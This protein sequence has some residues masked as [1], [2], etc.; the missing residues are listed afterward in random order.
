MAQAFSIPITCVVDLL[1]LE[2]DPRGP[3][4]GSSYNVKC[5]FCAD[6]GYHLNISELKNTYRC[7][8]CSGAQKGTGA[9]DLYGRVAMNTPH[10]PGSNGNGSY[11]YKRLREALGIADTS[12]L[13]KYINE[14]ARPRTQDILRASDKELDAAYS[15]LIKTV[16]FS[17]SE[18]HKYSLIKRGLDCSEIEKNQYRSIQDDLSWISMFPEYIRLYRVEGLGKLKNQVPALKRYSDNRLIAGFIVASEIIRNGVSVKGVPGFFQLGKRW[19]FR[20]DTGMIIPT[21]NE[22]GE[23]VSL[24]LRKDTGQLRYMTVSSKGF[25]MGVTEGISRTHFPRSNPEI[26]EKTTVILTEGPL[27]ADVALSLMGN[28]TAFIAMQGVN[29]TY[30]LPMV[31]AK[32]KG[33]G[34]NSVINA[35]DMDKLTNQNVSRACKTVRRIAKEYGIGMVMRCWDNE[36]AKTKYSELAKLCEINGIHIKDE[37][38][39]FTAISLMSRDLFAANVQHS[40]SIAEDGSERKNYWSALSKGIDDYLLMEKHK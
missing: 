25:P 23:I 21:R 26:N 14:N 40:V 2:R 6:K 4:Q 17:L 15:Q 39:I 3:K 29:N 7:V 11:L 13:K 18:H 10:I 9:L 24:Q 12:A 35:F 22:Y 20:V 19:C 8:L 30:E 16:H 32:L 34:V 5:P 38:N 28:S 27:K 37:Q 1:G 33:K 31:M 36:Y